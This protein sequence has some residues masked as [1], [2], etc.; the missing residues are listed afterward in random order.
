MKHFADYL[1]QNYPIVTINLDDDQ[2]EDYDTNQYFQDMRGSHDLTV[3]T[4][5][6]ASVLTKF[7][8]NLTHE[9]IRE[10]EANIEAIKEE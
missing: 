10:S 2:F 7:K 9:G 6:R 8:A 4:M 1:K 5:E 3:S